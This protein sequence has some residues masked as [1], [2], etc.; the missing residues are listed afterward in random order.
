MNRELVLAV[1]IV[2]VLGVISYAATMSESPTGFAVSA[3]KSGSYVGTITINFDKEYPLVNKI[4]VE[5]TLGGEW[6]SG[7][8]KVRFYDANGKEVAS[9]TMPSKSAHST[10]KTSISVSDIKVKKAVAEAGGC[11]YIDKAKATLEFSRPFTTYI[12]PTESQSQSVAVAG[13]TSTLNVEAIEKALNTITIKAGG[14]TTLCS[15]K[16]LCTYSFK[17]TEANIG[18]TITYTVDAVDSVGKSSTYTGSY[19][20]YGKVTLKK[21]G[22]NM[23]S[24]TLKFDKAYNNIQYVGIKLT[25]SGGSS[26]KGCIVQP[27]IEI[28]NAADKLVKAIDF[29]ADTVATGSAL[30][31]FADLPAGTQVSK[32]VFILGWER[33]PVTG[34]TGSFCPTAARYVDFAEANLYY[35]AK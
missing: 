33:V 19:K 7:K 22:A 21:S 11:L 28:Y 30:G 18:K 35:A 10:A 5:T 26:T 6:C 23:E 1:I 9:I 3:Q 2:L 8:A 24:Q 15:N 16:V 4:S 13:Q 27:R 31:M 25:P 20:V 14:M 32:F 29:S 12:T 34:G 17:E